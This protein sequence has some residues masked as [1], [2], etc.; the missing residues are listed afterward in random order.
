M[1]ES[2][3]QRTHDPTPR[4]REEFRKQGRF[5][6]ARDAGGVAAI[7]AVMGVLLGSREA[8]S[9]SVELLFA[10]CHGDLD[11]MARGQQ[12]AVFLIAATTLGALA[13]PAAV[14]GALAS[15]A[16]GLA[17]TGFNFDPGQIEIKPE[18]LNPLSRLKQLFSPSHAFF[19]TA[20]ALTRVG[21]VGL[22]AYTAVRDEVPHLLALGYGRETPTL[23]PIVDT[24]IR[25]TLRTLGVLVALAV[26]DYAHSRYKL[27]SELKM[28]LQE[29]KEEMR[30]QDGDPK[31]KARIRARARALAKRRASLDVR[32][33][34]V[35][36]T[37]PTHVAVALRY[38]DKDAA[39]VVI[40]KGHDDVA[41]Q[42]RAEARRH[43]IAIVESRALA[44]ALDA[45][46]PLGQPVP[47][48][49]FAAVAQVLAFVYKLRNRRR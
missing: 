38:S 21:A 35:V 4:R 7:A 26:V 9:R 8:A 31:V 34:A 47:G 27:E 19:E 28:T 33:A 6:R 29:L 5:A 17:Q 36:V 46:V 49:H 25:L 45:E 23:G 37:N 22:M 40:A 10:A 30:S 16:A 14:A 3:E 39:P 43:G 42:I 44:R 41:L 24:V 32:H 48:A 12:N 20:L 11:A 2:D 1:A 15:A 18:H 13:L